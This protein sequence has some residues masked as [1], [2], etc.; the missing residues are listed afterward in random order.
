MY[1]QDSRRTHLEVLQQVL[2][3]SDSSEVMGCPVEWECLARA[4]VATSQ[5]LVYLDSLS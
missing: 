1:G 5:T 2:I 4:E 3:T